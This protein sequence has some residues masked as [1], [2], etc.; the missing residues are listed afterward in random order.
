MTHNTG[1]KRRIFA[2]GDIHG[3]YDKL[4]LLMK[5]LPLDLKRDH[6]IFL[7]D[8]INRGPKSKQVISFLLELKQ[9][10]PRAVFLMGNHEHELLAYGRTGQVEH[11]HLL[12]E[13][14]V[15][16]TLQSYGDNPIAT[17]KDL[18][19]LPPDH[20]RFIE[21]LQIYHELDGYLFVHAGVAPGEDVERCPVHTLL[22]IRS[23]FL[24][25]PKVFPSRIVFGHTP[26]E[27]PLVTP[28]KI[29]IDTGAAYGNL[30]TAVDL[31]RLR[32]YHA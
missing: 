14:G 26:F 10:C 28:N 7:G 18:S 16:Q 4:V 15:E 3:C 30:L 9:E 2:I 27:T 19:F 6:L 29:G 11:L 20:R 21:Q 13:M 23:V 24:E 5:R 12:R 1:D 32:F 31:P 8:Y 22:N 25:C 17:L